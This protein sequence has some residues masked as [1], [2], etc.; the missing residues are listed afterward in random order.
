MA[1]GLPVLGY[2]PDLSLKAFIA[3][4]YRT[5]EDKR[6]FHILDDRRSRVSRSRR[7]SNVAMM[8][9][10]C[11]RRASSVHR[12]AGAPSGI[13]GPAEG[14]LMCGR[15]GASAPLTPPAVV[16]RFGYEILPN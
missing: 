1:V 6:V 3:C 4:Q 11:P 15:S 13:S 14:H 9:R 10:A 5:R 2:I 8:V 16:A 7:R 12:G